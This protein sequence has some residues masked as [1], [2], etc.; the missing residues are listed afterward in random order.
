M[1]PNYF[2]DAELLY[3]LNIDSKILTHK[4]RLAILIEV[5]YTN[6][7]GQVVKNVYLLLQS[8]FGIILYGVKNS[9][10]LYL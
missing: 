2:V 10:N 7:S 5:S 9:N 1:I 4:E 3:I 6:S 8:L